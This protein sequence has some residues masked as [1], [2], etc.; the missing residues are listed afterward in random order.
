MK[1]LTTKHY[2][3]HQF[4]PSRDVE[5]HIHSQVHGYLPTRNCA[6]RFNNASHEFSSPPNHLSLD[7]EVDI[8]LA[9][10]I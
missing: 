8:E 1:I 4:H 5:E 7:P 6:R 2:D 3:H 9:S 10:G